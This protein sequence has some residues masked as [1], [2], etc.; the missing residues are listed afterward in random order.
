LFSKSPAD[1]GTPVDA[2]FF[3]NDPDFQ[4]NHSQLKK[5]KSTFASTPDYIRFGVEDF[6]KTS[7]ATSYTYY[8]TEATYHKATGVSLTTD[9]NDTQRTYGS[10]FSVDVNNANNGKLS[11]TVNVD[12]AGWYVVKCQGFYSP[13]TSSTITANLFAT[14]DDI[15][16]TKKLNLISNYTTGTITSEPT[17]LNEAGK[18]FAANAYPNNV[19][20][21]VPLDNSS[22]T[23]GIQIDGSASGDW[24]AFD[25]FELEYCGTQTT[26]DLVLN[27]DFTEFDYLTHT[28]ESY[29]AGTTMYLHR[30]FNAGSDQ[31]STIVLPVS[32]NKK[33]FNDA[34]GTT[35]KLA[36]FVGL[37]G[38]TLR[39]NLIDRPDNDADEYFIANTPYIIN[40]VTYPTEG[41]EKEVGLH[42]ENGS[43]LSV[44]TGT[45]YYTI[46][47]V[48]LTD[49]ARKVL[50]KTPVTS[51]NNDA[52][53]GVTFYGT[54]V[55]TYTE[56]TPF[57]DFTT[58]TYANSYVM[59]EGLLH[60]VTDAYGLKGFRGWFTH[61]VTSSAKELTFTVGEDEVT[62]IVN[63]I[64]GVNNIKD[65]KVYNINGQLVNTTGTLEGLS[66]GI[67]IVNN[68]KYIV[69]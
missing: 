18:D 21:Y 66:K 47:G 45:Q 5:W 50:N 32:L 40:V 4:R 53:T 69:K 10:Y 36:K 49:E 38:E 6:Y 43:T 33:Q 19:M 65:N 7:S 63:V 61:K 39:F 35:A 42:L 52:S 64:D 51:T 3:M 24:T 68:K 17:N 8:G 26:A 11:Q 57:I 55:K 59:N 14:A 58:G 20:V 62:E 56:N 44:S 31:W 41:T 30:T 29:A 23:L 27:E 34:F 28:V 22:I 25:S 15:T 12:K 16:N 46:P 54:N 2:T 37:T 13:A 67:Y 9:D 48:V 60:H 1:L